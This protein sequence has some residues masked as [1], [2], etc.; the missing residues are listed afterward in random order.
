MF[1]MSI[2][3]HSGGMFDKND[4]DGGSREQAAREDCNEF[5]N[6]THRFYVSGTA[7]TCLAVTSTKG[8]SNDLN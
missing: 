4:L 6:L 8:S 7:R 3:S 2:F 5:G 1:F